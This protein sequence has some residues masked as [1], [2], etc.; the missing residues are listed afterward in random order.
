METFQKAGQAA[1]TRIQ[2]GDAQ[3]N[4]A[5][6]NWRKGDRPQAIRLLSR[7]ADLFPDR[8]AVRM[9]LA[10]WR[11]DGPAATLLSKQLLQGQSYTHRGARPPS[12]RGDYY[13]LGKLALLDGKH[14]AALDHF[15]KALSHW[16][17]L[18]AFDTQ[19]DCL[20]NAYLQL[21]RWE[22]ANAEYQR[23]LRLFPG[24]ALARFHLA[25]AFDR[26]GRPEAAREE[27]KRFLQLWK[28][29]DPDIPEVL[30]ANQYRGT[31]LSL[32]STW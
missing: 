10:L 8:P 30:A 2:Q 5:H 27:L 14:D 16:T 15:R 22:E 19:E 9:L 26:R 29:A 32:P 6:L 17:G 13:L 11:G 31:G 4:L 12:L 1:P 28:Q 23:V 18:A 3:F 25:V 20:G 7:A 21:W 24:M